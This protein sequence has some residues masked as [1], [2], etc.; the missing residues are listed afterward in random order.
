MISQLE[1]TTGFKNGKSYLKD[2]FFT[3]PYHIVNV[4][5]YENDNSLYLMMTS[6]SPGI[7]DRDEY[8]I[9]IKV[10]SQSR[11]QLRTQ[12]YQRLF[13]MK[14]GSSQ[15][16]Q[17]DLEG[18]SAFSFVSHP[19]VPHENAKF[20]NHNI[21]TLKENCLLTM[22]EIITCGRKHSGEVFQFSHFQN[23]TEVYYQGRLILKDNVLLEPLLVPLNTVVQLETYTHQGALIHIHTGGRPLGNYIA[24]I[25]EIFEMQRDILFGISEMAANGFVLRV[26]G[27]GAEQLFD[28]FK[29]VEKLLWEKNVQ[30]ESQ[31]ETMKQ[32]IEK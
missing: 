12:S 29:Q 3:V 23:L 6:S 18:N 20:K 9:A 24:R 10:V 7:L 4:G 5:Q 8:H 31:V 17:V 2:T 14:K 21:I 11:L 27:N 32:M 30:G 25:H 13:N 1:I 16:M 28:C 26:L 15:K 22:S 19:I